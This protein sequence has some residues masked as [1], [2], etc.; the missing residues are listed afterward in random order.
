M[1]VARPPLPPR[2]ARTAASTRS[3]LIGNWFSRRPVPSKMV[4]LLHYDRRHRR[5]VQAG[6]QVIVGENRRCAV[7]LIKD[8]VRDMARRLTSPAFDYSSDCAQARKGP[9]PP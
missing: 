2:C 5:H 3:V 4:L 1:Y 9:A 7:A 6:G 8:P